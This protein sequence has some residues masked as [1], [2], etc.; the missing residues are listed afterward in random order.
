[1]R[2]SL[3]MRRTLFFVAAAC[4]ALP[5]PSTYE[6]RVRGAVTVTARGSAESGPVGTPEEPYYTITLG[7]PDGAVAVV[8]TRAGS[9]IPPV[10][11]Y[12]VGERE[13]GKD[14][15]SGLIITGMPAHPTGV[16]RVQSGTLTITAAT[17]EHLTGRFELRAVGFLTESPTH[18]GR[19]VT[20]DG[21]FAARG[22]G[23]DST[24]TLNRERGR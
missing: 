17:P 13:L 15:F 19:E 22:S 18:D 6:V 9:A 1:M 4:W 23:R 7:G 24:L 16:F 12:L 20:A 14:G 11:V 5:N 3:Q 21:S 2:K 8:F 10:G